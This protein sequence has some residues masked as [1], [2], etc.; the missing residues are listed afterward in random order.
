MR[1]VFCRCFGTI[2]TLYA[3]NKECISDA[4]TKERLNADIELISKKYGKTIK[5]DDISIKSDL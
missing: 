4:V 3:L 5:K 1:V 2:Q